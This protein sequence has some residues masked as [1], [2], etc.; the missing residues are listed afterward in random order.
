MGF[1]VL[2]K[3]I[4]KMWYKIQR[5]ELKQ[6]YAVNILFNNISCFV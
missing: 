3:R 6:P 4:I 5:F 2:P 1:G